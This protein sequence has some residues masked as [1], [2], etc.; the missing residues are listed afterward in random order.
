VSIDRE[1]AGAYVL[2]AHLQLDE[3]VDPASIGA[4]VTVEL[5]GH[6]EHEGKC[7][8]P[9]NSD[10]H[11][12]GSRFVFRTLWISTPADSVEVQTRITRALT[13][14][15]HAAA[16]DMRRRPVAAGEEA[17]AERLSQSLS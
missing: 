11:E 10:I 9:H 3:G 15:Q 17:L 16:T 13:G 1:T 5:C 7:R 4:A 14:I 8:W 6:W 2:Q 12:D